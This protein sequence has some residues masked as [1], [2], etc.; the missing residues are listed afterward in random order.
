MS[1]YIPQR[2]RKQV[3]VLAKGRC[4][5]CQSSEALMGV[6]FEIDHI[7]PL[8]V[9][10]KT[11][12]KNLCLSCPTCNRYKAAHLTAS[13]P[14][15]GNVVSLFHPF[16]QIWEEHFF[17]SDDG[18]RLVGYSPIGRA[19]INLLHINRQAI[20]QLRR[21]WIALNLHPPR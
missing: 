19:T 20:V 18:L 2:L 16:E 14:L 7:I 15:T 21:Y 1:A 9:G 17:W 4:A 12:F 11:T 8:S 5:Y 10:G 3:L 6:K 13:D